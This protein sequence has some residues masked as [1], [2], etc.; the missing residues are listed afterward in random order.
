MD[1]KEKLERL[2]RLIN[3]W[4]YALSAGPTN[5]FGMDA[6][7]IY[8]EVGRV[9]VERLKKEG[10]ELIKET[11]LDT[12]NS[13]YSYF[14]EHGYF[15]EARAKKIQGDVYEFYEKGCITF[16]SNC[17]AFYSGECKSPAC[18]CYNIFRYTLSS[19]FGLDLRLIDSELK[20]DTEEEFAKVELVPV[21]KET[22]KAMSLMEQLR[23][24]EVELVRDIA[25]R[26][27]SEEMLKQR[28]DEIERIN[29]LMIGRELKMEEMRKEI[30][31]L[32]ARIEELEKK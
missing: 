9:A 5:L 27:H 32:K 7:Y 13:V 14:V 6:P 20:T 21:S 4:N 30:N 11:P 1:Y 28:L 18:F 2:N 23:K 19:R 12:V 29:K 17:W 24:N 31:R 26:K 25:E 10:V 8:L 16:E 22:V 3:L 15:E